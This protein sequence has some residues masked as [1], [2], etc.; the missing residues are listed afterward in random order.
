MIID[1]HNLRDALIGTVMGCALAW[2]LAGCAAQTNTTSS[3]A[4]VPAELTAP[5]I[6]HIA[7]PPNPLD[8]LPQA[9]RDNLDHPRIIREG[10]T[11][12]FPYS[13]NAQYTITCKPLFLTS[14]KLNP[15]EHIRKNGI[16][17]GDTARWQIEATDQEVRVK[18]MEP[19]GTVDMATGLDIA[20]DKRSYLLVVRSAGNYMPNVEWY[21]PNDIKAAQAA[22]G[23]ALRQ[24]AQQVASQPQPEP[25]FC[26]YQISGDAPWRPS[27]V[28]SDSRHEYIGLTAAPGADLPSLMVLEGNAQQLTNYRTEGNWL[29]TDRPFNSAVLTSGVGSQRQVVRIE[30]E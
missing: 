27:V 12:L 5:P 29:E 6:P 9:V 16:S 20:T 30:R 1:R 25:L 10:V 3:Q 15:D 24:Q 28:C 8:G 23:T 17:L 14:I 18:P 22:H 13:P 4:Y 26:G 19:L 11:T 21:Y 2:L 7:I